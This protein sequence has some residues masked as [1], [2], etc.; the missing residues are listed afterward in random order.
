MALR[1]VIGENV[2]L[3]IKSGANN[4]AIQCLTTHTI[5]ASQEVANTITKCGR[6]KTPVGDAD[7]QITGEGQIYLVDGPDLTTTY[8]VAKIYELL[9]AKTLVEVVSGPKS[10][11][12]VPGD[13]TY[14]GKGYVTQLEQTYAAGENSTFSFTIDIDGEFTQT[15]EPAA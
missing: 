5:T 13:I 15:V 10:G 11:T 1:R 12:P 2:W 8:S 6:V 9:N 7:I 4:I 3:F 14:E